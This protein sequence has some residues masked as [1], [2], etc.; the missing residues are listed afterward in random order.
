[1]IRILEKHLLLPTAGVNVFYY[2]AIG[3]NI[4]FNVHKT[5]SVRELIYNLS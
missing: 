1:M 5:A 4:F 2:V 3:H